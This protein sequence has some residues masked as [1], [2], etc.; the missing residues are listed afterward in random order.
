MNVFDYYDDNGKLKDMAYTKVNEYEDP[1][2]GPVEVVIKNDKYTLDGT[3]VIDA[4]GQAVDEQTRQRVI[5]KRAVDLGKA[6]L[7]N[8]N[9]IWYVVTTQG[10]IFNWGTA[11]VDNL[12]N[13]I[14]LRDEILEKANNIYEGPSVGTLFNAAEL[15]ELGESRMKFCKHN[16]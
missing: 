9:G 14:K 3:N 6:S 12:G 16:R 8:V 1:E 4:N 11:S 15:K 5:W 10:L 7:V 2:D 13:N